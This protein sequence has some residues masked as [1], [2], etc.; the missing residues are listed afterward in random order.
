MKTILLRFYTQF[1]VLR[2]PYYNEESCVFWYLH[3]IASVILLAYYLEL[4]LIK[5][6]I[7]ISFH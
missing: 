5:P 3:Q 4:N 2:V 7:F 6:K 1:P